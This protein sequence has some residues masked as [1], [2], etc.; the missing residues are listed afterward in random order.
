M[1]K[2][3]QIREILMKYTE[4]KIQ[5][6]G[7]NAWEV[8]GIILNTILL[9]PCVDGETCDLKSSPP[10]HWVGCPTRSKTTTN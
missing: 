7:I 1:N 4:P 9:E 3:Q 6:N 2:Q 8:A 5:F 10:Y